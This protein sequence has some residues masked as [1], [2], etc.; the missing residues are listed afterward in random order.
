MDSLLYI[1][2]Y[3]KTN[4][5]QKLLYRLITQSNYLEH[6]STQC[7]CIRASCLSLS[8]SERTFHGAMLV[9]HRII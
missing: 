4:H 8:Q 5:I 3:G 1:S 6:G 2:V 7:L 9:V